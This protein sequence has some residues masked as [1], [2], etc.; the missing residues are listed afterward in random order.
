MKQLC[1]LGAVLLGALSGSL[2]ADPL[3]VIPLPRAHSHNDYEH[4]RPLRDALDQG[5]CS[6]EADIYLVDGELLVAHDRAKV[7]PER[8][9]QALYLD[10]LRERV[11][12][13]GGSVYRDGPPVVL[14]ID[15]K[16]DPEPTWAALNRVLRT[17]TNMLTRFAPGRIE[18]NAVTVVISGNRARAKLAAETVRFAGLDGRPE[19]LDASEGRDLIPL[20]S[21]DWKRLFPWRG[22]GSFSKAEQQRLRAFVT[23]AHQAGRKVRFWGT[24]DTRVMWEL[25]LAY[26]VDFIN[27]DNL[28]GL[29]EFLQSR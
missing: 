8:T 1:I 22:T 7:R 15:V 27:A 17:Y 20:I 14:L 11:R 13:N 6:V 18:T 26:D 19:D 25:L 28:E 10:P 12:Q 29:R 5:F 2:G 21:E 3:S 4:A 24:P 16:S 23:K 9:L